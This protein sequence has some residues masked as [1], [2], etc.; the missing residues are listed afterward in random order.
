MQIGYINFNK[1]NN[2]EYL[3]GLAFVNS[4]TLDLGRV[5]GGFSQNETISPRRFFKRLFLNNKLYAKDYLVPED[6]DK[7]SF[8]EK[9]NI[10]V[11]AHEDL[12]LPIDHVKIGQV[13]SLTDK[14][15]N[16]LSPSDY[17]DLVENSSFDQ[18]KPFDSFE[19]T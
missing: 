10:L 1:F 3:K 7:I 17:M 6:W 2:I 4:T 15:V 14:D 9:K 13:L 5:I 8:N 18:T 16:Y 12:G 11:E 19:F